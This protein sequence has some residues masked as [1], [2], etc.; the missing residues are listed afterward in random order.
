[1]FIFRRSFWKWFLV[2]AIIILLFPAV[3]VGM[4]GNL[5]L[6]AAKSVSERPV[7]IVFG[8]SVW[9]RRPSPVFAARLQKAIDLYYAGKVKTLLVTGD[10]S[11]LHYNEPVAGQK[12]LL[13]AGIP[14][15]DI[16]LDYAGF[17]TYDSCFRAAQIFEV[18]DAILV[19]Q[20]LHLPRAV[21]LCRVL[22]VRAVGVRA[23]NVAMNNIAHTIL[24]EQAARWVSF[25]EGSMFRHSPTALGEKQPVTK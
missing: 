1:M 14:K 25:W 20:E 4:Y 16:V 2:V 17:R 7:G 5:F 11:E 3:F 9:G 18:H 21:F 12:F 15:E 13:S 8:T 23:D 6:F 24:R 19:T 10:N 22:G